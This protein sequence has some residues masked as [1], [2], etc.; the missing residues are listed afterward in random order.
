MNLKLVNIYTDEEITIENVTAYEPNDYGTR[1]YTELNGNRD[2]T[3]YLH[4]FIPSTIADE[5]SNLF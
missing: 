3:T 5:L 4:F 1:V 2:M